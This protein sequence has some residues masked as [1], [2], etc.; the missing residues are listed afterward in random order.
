MAVVVCLS[1]LI[2]P[3]V[4]AAAEVLQVGQG[5]LLQVG[6]RN[7]T[8]GVQLACV[9][10]GPDHQEEALRL[11]RDRLPRHS[12]VNLRPVGSVDGHLLAQVRMLPG[13]EDL[14]STLVRA[15]LAEPLPDDLL[16]Q[17]CPSNNGNSAS[18]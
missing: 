15:G 17:A 5:L 2:C 8:Y 6:D 18:A 12:R 1:T 9:Q 13:G 3:G 11:T 16:P 4:A 10:V 7:R 14:G